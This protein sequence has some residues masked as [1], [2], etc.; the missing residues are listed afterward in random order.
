LDLN[1]TSKYR[2]TVEMFEIESNALAYFRQRLKKKKKVLL[3]LSRMHFN[4][5]SN[6]NFNKVLIFSGK[7]DL[8]I[9]TA[10]SRVMNRTKNANFDQL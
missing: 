5:I 10:G 1:P 9:S 7:A 4:R 6:K 8:L 2:P 3:N